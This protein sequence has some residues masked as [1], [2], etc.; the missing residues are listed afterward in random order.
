MGGEIKFYK[1]SQAQYDGLAEIGKI[2]PDALYFIM[3]KPGIYVGD[4]QLSK[5]N[6]PKTTQTEGKSYMVVFG[7]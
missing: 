1:C 7:E 6:N 4:V 5:M 3:D 2:N